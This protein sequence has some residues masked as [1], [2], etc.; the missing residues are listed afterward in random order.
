[1]KIASLTD[2]ITYNEKRPAI[3]IM[4][5]TATSKEIRIVFK[6]GQVMKEHQTP[7]P[8]VVQIFS[9][10]IDFGVRGDKKH[11]VAGSLISLEGGVP[12]DLRA[13]EDSVVRLSLSKQDKLERLQSIET[14]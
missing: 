11:L 12:H 13:L 6:K 3:N 8:I 2:A 4:L 9:G 10:A 7:F 1:M 14:I 5:E